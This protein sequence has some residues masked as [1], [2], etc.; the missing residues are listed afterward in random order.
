MSDL[1]MIG[2]AL[3]FFIASFGLVKLFGELMED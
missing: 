1:I 2:L 3:A